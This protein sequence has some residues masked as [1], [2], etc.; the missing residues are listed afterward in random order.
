M[1]KLDVAIVS[2]VPVPSTTT[3]AT[4]KFAGFLRKTALDTLAIVARNG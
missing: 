4:T 2:T 1:I 3:S